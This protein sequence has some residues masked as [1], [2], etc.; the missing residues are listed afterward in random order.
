MCKE[1]ELK[2]IQLE[3]FKSVGSLNEACETASWKERARSAGKEIRAWHAVDRLGSH[4][5]YF[6]CDDTKGVQ[7]AGRG[8]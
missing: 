7:D 4:I 6:G 3:A 2:V 8:Q 1:N 5:A